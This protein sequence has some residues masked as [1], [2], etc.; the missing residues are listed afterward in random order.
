MKNET[1]SVAL[2]VKDEEAHLQKTIDSLKGIYDELV[3]VDTGSKDRTKEI[4]AAAGAKVFDLDLQ[5]FRFD[6]ARNFS[7]EKCTSDW[8]L[9]IDADD[10]LDNPEA[11]KTVIE[12][13]PEELDGICATYNY[14]FD[15]RGLCVA[16]HIKERLIRNNGSMIWLGVLHEAMVQNRKVN[17]A[18]TDKFAVSHEKDADGFARSSQRNYDIVKKWVEDEGLEKT[19]PRNILSLANA[20][21]G[22]Q[23]HTEA[24]PL[25]DAFIRRSGW[26]EEIYVALHRMAICYRELGMHQESIECDLRAVECQPHVRDAYISLGQTYMETKQWFKSEHWLKQ[27]FS[28]LNNKAAVI[29]NPAEYVFNPWWF[30]GHVYANLSSEGKGFEYVKKAYDC[31]LKCKEVIPNDKDIDERLQIFSKT[32]EDRRLAESFL[33]VGAA[34]KAEKGD[35]AV[36]S[37]LSCTPESIQAD[38]TICKMRSSVF[39]KLISSG[40][41][42]SIFC[43]NCFEEWDETN[44][45]KGIGGSE[46]AVIHMARRLGA[47]GWNVEIFNSVP[48]ARTFGNV[49]YRPFWEFN[50]LD[51]V[52]VF[53]SWRNPA[54]FEYM[55]VNA[56][57]RYVWVHD[58][59]QAGEFTEARW[60]KCDKIMFLS[61]AHRDAYPHVPEEKV[62]YT[63]NGIDIEML[64][65]NSKDVERI[66]WKMINTSA[67]DRGLHCLLTMWPKIKEKYPEATF[68]WYYGWQT[69]DSYN[70]NNPERMAFKDELVKLLKQPGVFEGGRISHQEIAAEMASSDLWVYPTEFFETSCITAMKAQALGAVPV[71]TNVGALKET[72]FSGEKVEST[73]IYSDEKAQ[74]EWIEKLEVARSCDRANM[75]KEALSRFNWD[76]VADGWEKE[77]YD[78][79]SILG[80]NG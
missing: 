3:V 60:S 34:L 37:L 24:I 47:K 31:F 1:L 42:I 21:L 64:L 45:E 12:E 61:K 5:P 27:S 13:A 78:G 17:L 39:R 33:H 74:T 30:L 50:Y 67:P 52:D 7:F 44:L 43:G 57:Q 41:D 75:Q 53:I 9:W 51:A 48:S 6:S 49:T 71:T 29:H 18:T 36:R 23:K 59:M 66:P 40:K 19:D 55:D 58:M 26:D 79:K 16:R 4:A 56:K 54:L 80:S 65:E 73:S 68:Y 76:S 25:F 20:C 46:E 14:A 35:E 15:H 11:I 72:V 38:P 10:R 62:L 70:A 28:K 22:L 8:I 32:L 77:F 69:Y 2:I 63:A